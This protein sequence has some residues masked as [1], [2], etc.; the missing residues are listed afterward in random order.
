MR[1]IWNVYLLLFLIPSIG[2]T[3]V[4]TSAFESGEF[5]KYKINYGLLNA[6]FM[7]L[8]IE[9]SQINNKQLLHV[10]GKGWTTGIVNFVFPVKDN[11]QTYFYQES[12]KPFKFIRKINE[13]GYIKNKE[14][15]FDFEEQQAE[16]IDYKHNTKKSFFIQ[17][18]VQDMLS[19][20]FYLRSLDLSNLKINEV[21]TLNMF[22][23]EQINEIKLH[24][25]GKDI[26]T[27][28]FGKV[29]TLVFKPMVQSGRVFKDDETVTFWVTDDKNKIPIKIKAE[30]LVG[31]I[32]ADLIEYK[33]LANSFLIIFN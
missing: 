16:V 3:Q 23:D 31:S 9:S 11:Y 8:K 29:K 18:D 15:Y 7:S 21:I 13:G 5:L 14:I 20:L 2:Y 28:K 30:I 19:S 24:Y 22:F 1:K 27:T 32:K 6:G 17:N 4:N 10:N 26:I 33:G 25:K 12:M